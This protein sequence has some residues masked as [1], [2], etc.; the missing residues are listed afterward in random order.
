MSLPDAG[1]AE[2]IARRQHDHS[3]F[4]AGGLSCTPAVHGSCAM[5]SQCA[6]T[7]R[8]RKLLVYLDQNFMS[9]MAKPTHDRVRPDFRELYSVLQQGF[10]NEQLVVLRSSFHDVET[11]L[12]GSLRDAIRAR[13]ST[14]GHGS[15]V[16]G[17]SRLRRPRNRNQ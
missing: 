9:E 6:M 7:S 17:N 16:V 5:T 13:R 3:L 15:T 2:R 1:G 14:L 4:S 10:W 8:P 12:A 11:S